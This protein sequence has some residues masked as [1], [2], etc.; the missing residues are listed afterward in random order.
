MNTKRILF[1][2]RDNGL[3]EMEVPK[4]PSL[5]LHLERLICQNDA[6]SEIYS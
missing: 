4:S 5:L 1:G 2:H 3:P 6:I